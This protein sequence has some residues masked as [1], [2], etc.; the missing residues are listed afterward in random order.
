VTAPSPARLD[1]SRLDGPRLDGRGVDPAA[2]D[3]IASLRYALDPAAMRE[4]L[5]TTVDSVELLSLKPGRRAVVR[6]RTPAGALIG[7]IRAGH[8]P[9][10]PFRLMERFRAVGFD[11]GPVQVAEPVAVFEDLE[12]WIQRAAPGV[13]GNH[14]LD[15]LGTAIEM[16][17]T[18]AAAV[19]C[20]HL[21]GVPTKRT[22]SIDHEL[23]VLARRLS[24]AAVVRPDLADRLGAL[25]QACVRRSSDARDVSARGGPTGI[26]RD[27]YADQF[28]FTGLGRPP[29]GAG[30]SADGDT[31]VRTIGPVTTVI[32]FDLYC[33]GD[34]AL[35]VGNF[36]AHL[37][38]HALRTTGNAASLAF[39]EA[40][41]RNAFLD[42][43]GG[44]HA[45]AV[46]V[47]ADLTL[48][49]HVALSTTVPGRA[50]LTDAIIEICEA[51][52]S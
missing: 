32:D 42:L 40:E 37:T 44:R 30:C 25:Q 3:S 49:R 46:D 7:K 36:V 21:A 35:D 1:G 48:A 45:V 31:G 15:D 51:R 39:A 43:A 12:M 13:P 28:L 26:H 4:L 41:C 14:L 9:T 52:L 34:P 16:A 10:S 29:A 47:Y 33:L 23:E 24:A 18:A 11:R 27:A 2:L 50:H 20:V 38:E 5:A 6:Y 17:S 8:R 19:H 22:H